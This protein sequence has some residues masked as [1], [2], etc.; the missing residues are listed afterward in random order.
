MKVDRSL[1]AG[2]WRRLHEEALEK[3]FTFRTFPLRPKVA[4]VLR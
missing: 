4:V 2:S 1:G 3:E